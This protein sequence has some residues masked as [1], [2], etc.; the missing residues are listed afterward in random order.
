MAFPTNPIDN[1][2]YTNP[3][4]TA[5][6]YSSDRTAWLIDSQVITGITGIQGSTGISGLSSAFTWVI[7]NPATGFIPGPKLYQDFTCT[8]I[9]SFVSDQTS[10]GFNIQDRTLAP[11]TTG[12]TLLATDQTAVVDGIDSTIIQNAACPVNSWMW[13][14][15][16]GTTGSP[17]QLMVTITGTV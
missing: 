3:L 10:C 4:G 11:T 2:I 8:K 16:K 15:I 14:D 12:L 5:W 13:L 6:K 7:T 1:E 17:T 9:S